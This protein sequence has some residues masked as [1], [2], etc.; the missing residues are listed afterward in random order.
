MQEPLLASDQGEHLAGD[1]QRVVYF[2]AANGYAVLRITLDAGDGEQV[3]VGHI[4]AVAAGDR[5]QAAG[6]WYSDRQWGR[7][8]RAS[9]ITVVPPE[10][11]DGVKRMLASGLLQGIG[12][13]LASLL[14]SRFG[15]ELFAIIEEDPEQ[16]LEV[17][18]IGRKRLNQ[19]VAS[20]KEQQ[21]VGRIMEF[22]Q[23]HQIAV[24]KAVR[25]FRL[26]GTDAV[27][28]IT[29]NPYRL[30]TDIPGI[31]FPTADRIARS[32]EVPP[33]APERAGAALAHQLN[34][35]SLDGHCCLPATQLIAA[36]A[37]T[38][39]VNPAIVSERLE[40]ELQAGRLIAAGEGEQRSIYLPVL[41]E[42][43]SGVAA[44]LRR[45]VQGRCSWHIADTDTLIREAEAAGGIALSASQRRAVELAL[46]SPCTVITGGPGVGKTTIIRTIL[47]ILEQ[48]GS[49]V[50]LAAPTGRAAKRLAEA[51]DHEAKTIHRLLEYDPAIQDFRRNHQN[52]L[53][54][55]LVVVDEASMI[56]VVL[57][58][59]L[60]DAIPVH[61]SLIIVGDIDQLPPVGP[62]FV[63]AGIIASQRI[64]VV[65]LDQIFRQ[66]ER[67]GIIV[68][69]H[70][71]NRGDF[72]V[73]AAMA[74]PPG[75]P[76][77]FYIVPARDDDD[78]R[79]KLLR[80]ILERIPARFGFEWRSGI[81][82]L[83]PM[84]KG[85]LG[86]RSLNQLLQAQLN[87]HPES[88]ITRQGM[89]Y[90]PGDRVIQLVNDYDKEVFNGDIGV[91]TGTDRARSRLLL[92]FDGRE[93]IHESADLD[94]IS[95][96]YA[97]TIHKSQGSEYPAVVIPVSRQHGSM[98]DRNLLYTAVTRARKL[99]VLVGDPAVI[100]QAVSRRHQRA[101]QDNLAAMINPGL[102]KGETAAV[103]PAVSPAVPPVS[104]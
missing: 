83:T 88:W 98:L 21:G 50:L 53:R 58:H 31:G 26:Y 82:L 66:A 95:L 101:K 5:I 19:I 32:L 103:L 24:N 51:S 56:D 6:Q 46:A 61:A 90:A 75:E 45:L 63:L 14:V 102:F 8:F 55:D 44:S 64:P 52:P 69:A 60:L 74:D 20:W 71:I 27:E 48:T 94:T 76:G 29:N 37:R 99:V 80:L 43:E 15:T 59:C 18:G 81:Q 36:V 39:Q 35:R 104:G 86:T 87:P 97:I 2:N 67:S 96:A 30:M 11:R 100:E 72:N 7:Q 79:H 41:H 85:E 40:E 23:S 47:A 49:V 73:R 89:N 65:C 92:S 22:L 1:V 78:C 42:A 17:P 10:T 33:D 77:D 54:A 3:V 34:E 4:A 68:S 57:M 9:A 25:I 70:S 62:G 38:L 12:P 93:V 84:N 91:V 28:L 13:H 16:L